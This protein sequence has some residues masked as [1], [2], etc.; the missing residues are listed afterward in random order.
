MLATINFV[1]WVIN[2]SAKHVLNHVDAEKI[3]TTIAQS[4]INQ[5]PFGMIV[6][7]AESSTPIP[8]IVDQIK[9]SG[10]YAAGNKN[11][12]AFLIVNGK[13]TIAQ[14]GDNIE[15]VTVTKVNVDGIIVNDGKQD[16]KLSISEN[17]TNT[18]NGEI[19]SSSNNRPSFTPNDQDDAP[20]TPQNNA[21]PQNNNDNSSN[22]DNSNNIIAERKK[23]IEQF[24]QQNSSH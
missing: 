9:I 7:E 14:I 13:N 1:W 19:N 16:I 8:S 18:A 2:P 21:S 23:M 20:P 17:K 5:A 10:V 12:V 11:S 15:G 4:I 22:N 3:D 6:K 24:Q